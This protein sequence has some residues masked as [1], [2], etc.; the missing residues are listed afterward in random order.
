MGITM[1][2]E[3]GVSNIRCFVLLIGVTTASGSIGFALPKFTRIPIGPVGSS[4]APAPA[5]IGPWPLAWCL[6]G[7][8][9][10]I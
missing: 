5:L 7:I 2:D 3:V 10:L 1:G 8:S 9:I 6:S 4:V